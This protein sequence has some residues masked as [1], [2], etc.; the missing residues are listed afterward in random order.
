MGATLLYRVRLKRALDRGVVPH[1]GIPE[2]HSIGG[3]V[4][5][6]SVPA[7]ALLKRHRPIAYCWPRD[8]QAATTTPS[9]GS[10]RRSRLCSRL[11]RPLDPK[12]P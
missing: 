9:V 3:L 10:A 11:A 8:A 4:L 12:S 2:S 6:D 1:M 7:P 5:S